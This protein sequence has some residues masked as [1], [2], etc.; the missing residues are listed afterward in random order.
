MKDD[1]LYCLNTFHLLKKRFFLP[2]LQAHT[3]TPLKSDHNSPV[4]SPTVLSNTF[5]TSRP[6]WG[7]ERC[8]SAPSLWASP[9]SFPWQ[10][11]GLDPSLN[12]KLMTVVK[13]DHVFWKHTSLLGGGRERFLASQS[14]AHSCRHK[15][16]KSQLTLASKVSQ[17]MVLN[18]ED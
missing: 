12:R 4:L 14:S 10:R 3:A 5:F 2:Q 8:C 13:M 17:I 18:L 1:R 7:E 9:S 15:A 11:E 16:E 6:P